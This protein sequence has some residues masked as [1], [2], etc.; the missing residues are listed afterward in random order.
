MTESVCDACGHEG[1]FY[2]YCKRADYQYGYWGH[3]CG[4][5]LCVC[6]KHFGMVWKKQE[7]PVQG[8]EPDRRIGNGDR[9]IKNEKKVLIVGRDVEKYDLMRNLL[10]GI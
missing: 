10:E 2:H 1:S 5:P 3:C 9:R 8:P 7:E 6:N 4:A